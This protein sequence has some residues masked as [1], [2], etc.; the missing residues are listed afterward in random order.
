MFNNLFNRKLYPI[1][2]T[3]LLSLLVACNSTSSG[4]STFTKQSSTPN[5]NE[6][7]KQAYDG[8]KARIAVARFTDKSNNAYWYNKEIGD[9]MADQLTTALFNTNRF[10]VLERQALDAVTAEQDLAAMGRVSQDTAAAYGE[11][12]GAEIVVVASVTEFK[13]NASGGSVGGGGWVGNMI[14]TVSAGFS[15]AHMAVDIRLI[16]TRTSRILAATNIEG[17]TTDFDF[18]AAALNFGGSIMGGGLSGWSNTPKEKALREVI[19]KAVAF[20]EG[21]VPASYYRYDPNNQP[22]HGQASVA[23]AP[24]AAKKVQA[25]PQD[26]FSVPTGRLTRVEKMNIAM[27]RIH[28]VCLGYLKNKPEYED[29]EVDDVSYDRPTVAALRAYQGENGFAVTG[30]ADKTTK[31]ALD[32]SECIAQSNAAGMKS[33]GSYFGVDGSN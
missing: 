28:L 3:P 7:A 17:G 27:S 11:I 26:E 20:L 29:F 12:E 21:K 32:K 23:K 8:P 4:S 24:V 15:G 6:V 16:D 2:I 1:L 14:S 33:L 9:G 30:L 13:D 18:S 19:I 10:I 25:K 31:E 5:V 22:V